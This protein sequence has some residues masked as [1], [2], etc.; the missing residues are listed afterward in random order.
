MVIGNL[1]V[2]EAPARFS[3][4]FTM[5]GRTSRG[6]RS[7]KLR[8]N[9]YEKNKTT[10]QGKLSKNRYSK[11]NI[12][13]TCTKEKTTHSW[14]RVVGGVLEDS[15]RDNACSFQHLLKTLEYLLVGQLKSGDHARRILSPRV[16]KTKVL[17]LPQRLNTTVKETRDDTEAGQALLFQSTYS[18]KKRLDRLELI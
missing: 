8:P 3:P 2:T 15:K 6:I 16:L 12:E 7:T 4:V 13:N 5:V 18:L 11:R 1:L 14:R 10:R 9:S 17:S